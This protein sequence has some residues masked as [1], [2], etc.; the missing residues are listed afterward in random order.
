M[1]SFFAPNRNNREKERTLPLGSEEGFFGQLFPRVKIC[2]FVEMRFIS[3][4]RSSDEMGD[5]RQVEEI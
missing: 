5:F 4:N 2:I 3:L 1:T